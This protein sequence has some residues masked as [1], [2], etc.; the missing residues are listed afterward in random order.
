MFNDDPRY[1][2]NQVVEFVEGAGYKVKGIKGNQAFEEYFKTAA[3]A[4]A[5]IKGFMFS[6]SRS[7]V[8]WYG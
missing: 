4:K 1:Q 5:Y 2:I 8:A 6:R 7:F 3:E